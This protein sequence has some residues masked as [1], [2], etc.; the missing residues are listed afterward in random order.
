M[1]GFV[2]SENT[3]PDGYPELAE[4]VDER[5]AEEARQRAEKAKEEA[6]NEIDFAGRP[7]PS[8]ER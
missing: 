5:R 1:R 6:E 2:A 8:K 4:E 3:V 7:L